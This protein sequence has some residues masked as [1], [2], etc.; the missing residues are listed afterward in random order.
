V[1]A[2]DWGSMTLLTNGVDYRTIR[3]VS[4][5]DPM[6]TKVYDCTTGEQIK[7]IRSIEWRIGMDDV[8][9]A[10]LEFVLAEVDVTGLTPKE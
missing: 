9:T 2:A 7:G 1:D 10:K 6:E 4:S 8:A 5:G 3:I